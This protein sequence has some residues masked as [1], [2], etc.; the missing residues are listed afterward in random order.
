M[1][2]RFVESGAS[3]YVSPLAG[4]L[5]AVVKASPGKL[6][7][8]RAVNTT[9]SK[10]YIWVCNE[11]AFAGAALLVPPIPIA[12]NEDKL[13]NLPYAL[14]FSTGLAISVSTSPTSY[15]AAGANSGQFHAVWK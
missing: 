7:Y 5:T 1:D 9:A 14:P 4:E 13:V 15:V 8:L 12:A 6:F 2:Y 10:V 3:S 11:S